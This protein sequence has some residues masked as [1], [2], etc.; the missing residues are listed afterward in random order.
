[1]EENVN[2]T[3]MDEFSVEKLCSI[4]CD[5][6]DKGITSETL[7]KEI[8]EDD[9]RNIDKLQRCIMVNFGVHPIVGDIISSENV[10]KLSSVIQNYIDSPKYLMSPEEIRRC[11]LEEAA[12][13]GLDTITGKL[14]KAEEELDKSL[15][16]IKNVT[17]PVG[18]IGHKT[19]YEW[20]NK[21]WDSVD[22][23]VSKEELTKVVQKIDTINKDAFDDIGTAI[24]AS[25]T[26]I[27]A[28]CKALIWIIKIEDD[29]Y[30]VSEESSSKITD[31]SRLL[32]AD[33]KNIE[34][35][36]KFGK[37]EKNRRKRIQQKMREFTADIE[38]KFDFLNDLNKELRKK[39]DE[40][41]GFVNDKFDKAENVLNEKV[42]LCIQE[43]AQSQK[44]FIS[45]SMEQTS[46]ALEA[47]S[48]KRDDD[49]MAMQKEQN[50]SLDRIDKLVNENIA[51]TEEKTNALVKSQEEFISQSKEETA[52]ALSELQKEAK[53]K[54][55]EIQ[56][57]TDG[58]IENQNALFDKMKKQQK[59]YKAVSIT[60]LA[61]SIASL[62]YGIIL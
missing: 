41:L 48:K 39:F 12:E 8:V 7:I 40:S 57:Q 22:T 42:S 25:N 28:I 46:Q 15:K 19:K 20:L 32:S 37:L 11:Q 51:K 56:E 17:A 58:F 10:L 33:G 55:T 23:K 62:L 50:E 44:D 43:L 24:S 38:G 45:Q 2:Y 61:V 35:L 14:T 34:G 30:D 49:I 18:E 3:Q 53:H 47:I 26:W 6:F 31:M 29:L 27:D 54:T 5:V 4:L 59:F 1:M 9:T 36:T 52:L 60:A 16:K 21:L 13:K